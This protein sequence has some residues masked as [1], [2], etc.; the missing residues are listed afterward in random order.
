MDKKGFKQRILSLTLA[1]L[2]LS[3]CSSTTQ[4]PETEG[5]QMQE[6]RAAAEG[7]A[8]KSTASAS[9]GRE[10]ERSTDGEQAQAMQAA[11]VLPADLQ[12]D[13][14]GFLIRDGVL[15]GY[16]P[17][18]EAEEVVIPEGV[19]E[20]APFAFRWEDGYDE[21]GEFGYGQIILPQGLEKIGFGAFQNC[22]VYVGDLPTSVTVIEPFAFATSQ[23]LNDSITIPEGVEEI[24]A[25]AFSNCW[26]S[27]LVLPASLKSIGEGAFMSNMLKT[28]AIPDGTVTIGDRAFA[29]NAM[30]AVD[31]YVSAEDWQSGENDS[32]PAGEVLIPDSVKSIGVG[33]F[34]NCRGLRKVSL[35]ETLTELGDF[36]FDGC[37]TLEELALPEGLAHLGAF[38]FRGCGLTKI[39]LPDGLKSIGPGCFTGCNGLIQISLPDGLT[40]IGSY[41]F[42]ECGKLGNVSI[43]GELPTVGEAAFENTRVPERTVA[44]FAGGAAEREEDAASKLT[45][46]NGNSPEAETPVRQILMLKNAW[47]ALRENGTVKATPLDSWQ[48]SEDDHSHIYTQAELAELERWTDII[49]LERSEALVAG[50]RSDGTVVAV[51]LNP[52]TTPDYNPWRIELESWTDVVA[53]AG[54][55]GSYFMA[56]LRRDGTLLTVDRISGA[57]AYWDEEYDFHFDYGYCFRQ[58]QQ[59]KELSLAGYPAVLLEDGTLLRFFDTYW[60]YTVMNEPG[61][62]VTA[63]E[64]ADTETLL[65]RTDDGSCLA[66]WAYWPVRFEV[67]S[68]GWKDMRQIRGTKGVVFGLKEDGSIAICMED[69]TVHPLPFTGAEKLESWREGEFW[70]DAEGW[71]SVEGI[72]VYFEDGTVTGLLVSYDYDGIAGTCSIVAVP[73]PKGWTGLQAYESI[74]GETGEVPVVGLKKDGTLLVMSP[75]DYDAWF[76]QIEEMAPEDRVL[77]LRGVD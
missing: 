67:L 2:F 59:V 51:G 1:A 38:A 76:E 26:L 14:N 11:W 37:E 66:D 3:G 30:E 48:I 70:D 43:S 17:Q 73:A 65:V 45:A 46:E 49:A 36:V 6:E 24:G 39:T 33:A 41:A 50:L 20:I 58:L 60:V 21:E 15:Y 64:D 75:D 31:A 5:Q 4:K 40:S 63:V 19:T 47:L 69:G 71:R 77:Q 7:T 53:L 10:A 54:D 22:E 56:G 44:R 72:T 18:A 27:E 62:K 34:Q 61:Q 55:P 16:R 68:D 28:I 35:P 29:W 9:S 23:C 25:Y 8:L 74:H 12:P 57:E 13:K 32:T 42:A 52:C